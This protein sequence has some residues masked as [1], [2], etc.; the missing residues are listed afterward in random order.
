[1][2]IYAGID[3]AGYG[4]MLGPLCV[5]CCVLS[6]QGW[7]EGEPGPDLWEQ[8]SSVIAPARKG[9]GKRIVVAD[10][11]KLKLP[12]SSKTH[13]PLTHLEPGVFTFLPERAGRPETDEALLEATC[14]KLGSAPWY[15]GDPISLPLGHDAGMLRI[16]V[17]QV[18]RAL[19]KAGVTPE[20]YTCQ[21]LDAGPFNDAIDRLHSKAATSFAMVMRA[22]EGVWQHFPEA[23]PR[24]MVDRQGGRA[25]YADAIGA[26]LPGVAVETVLESE[27]ISRYVLRRD[28][29][30]LTITFQTEAEDRHMPVALASMLAKYVRE[31]A[32]ARFNRFWAERLPG[33]KPTAGY[34]QD[35]RRWLADV[36]PALVEINRRQLVRYR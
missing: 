17:A 34:V 26:S 32:M 6:C 3:E 20:S 36:Q 24:V 12:N 15:R 29:S 14:T 23:H 5:G 7:Q 18:K 13:H 8:L 9:A 10:S 2:L 31:L 16:T 35:G 22:V 27:D 33:L 1:M 30:E 4:P 21:A 25:Q 11:K 19:L 28:G